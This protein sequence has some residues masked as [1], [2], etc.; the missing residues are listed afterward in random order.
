MWKV[1]SNAVTD[2]DGI[3]LELR[4]VAAAVGE[5]L[6]ALPTGWGLAARGAHAAQYDCDV[7]ADAVALEILYEA[8]FGVLSEETGLHDGDR[9]ILV[10]VDPIDGSTNASRGIPWFNTSMCAV[11]AEG[12][13]VALVV[14]HATGAVY[15]AV[16]GSGARRDGA[17]IAPSAAAALSESIVAVQG[18]PAAH[19]GWKQ[20]RALGAAAL[21]LCAVSDGT[22]DA[23]LDCAPDSLSPWDFAA[24]VLI[25][26]EAGAA[27]VDLEGRDLDVRDATQRRT[28]VAAS[29]PSLLDQAIS[30]LREHDSEKNLDNPLTR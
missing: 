17:S 4:R 11:D 25:C 1:A 15:E 6:G 30:A 28:I 3:L 27:V 22:V 9:E 18:W 21:D 14:N 19:L 23:Y 5:A 16:R 20:F 13:R 26:R 7:V 8:G 10:I 29:S 12:P 2:D 24:G